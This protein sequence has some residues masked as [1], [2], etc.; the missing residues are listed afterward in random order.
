[1][2]QKVLVALFILLFCLNLLI[3][4]EE[5]PVYKEDP[6]ESSE[7][8]VQNQ[9]VDSV[10][11]SLTFEERLGQLFMVAAYTDKH[12]SVNEEVSKLIREQT[13]GGLIFFH[14]GPERQAHLN[15]HVQSIAKTQLCIAMDA[16]WGVSMRLDSV[17]HFP[18]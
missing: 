6:L 4:K 8:T 1:M 16:E 17:P 2:V 12:N 5:V 15:N 9:W 13:I 3:A 18:K 14:G 10:F 7:V 11:N